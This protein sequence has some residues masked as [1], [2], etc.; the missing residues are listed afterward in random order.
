MPHIVEI[1]SVRDPVLDVY[2]RLTDRQL[3]A[4]AG[5]IIAES[6]HVIEAALERGLT[7]VS[8]LAAR[9]HVSGKAAKLIDRLGDIPVYTGEDETLAALTGYHLTRGVLC[10]FRRPAEPPWRS[11]LPASSRLA[12][13][14]DIRDAENMGAII[15]SAAALG[16][17]GALLS[18]GCA[19][20]FSRRAARVS[21]GAAFRLPWARVDGESWPDG[22]LSALNEQG[23][24]S[25]AMCLRP[26][27]RSIAD[28]SIAGRPKLAL[29]LGNEGDGLS[30]RAIAACN[31]QVMIDMHRG[32]DSLNVAAAAAVAFWAL[33]KQ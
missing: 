14:E 27:A 22:L 1:D 16:F 12:V 17:D 21:M 13:L 3:K 11:L 8:M 18:P 19:D 31:A 30:E 23:F 33:R 25:A 2:A 6:E 5:L 24:Y 9:R 4:G 28:P 10:A 20:P 26:G 7:P 15:R 29:L 32:V